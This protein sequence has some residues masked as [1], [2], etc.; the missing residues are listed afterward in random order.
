MD[1]D[2]EGEIALVTGAGRGIGLAIAEVLAAEGVRVIAGDRSV[3][4]SLRD[5]AT[6]T[7]QVDLSTRSGPA[8]LVDYAVAELG[9]VDILVNNVGG[10]T[11]RTDGF[12]TVDDDEWQAT[13][14]LNFFA[15]VRATR[16][17]LPA[18]LERKGVIINI[19]SLNARRPQPPAVD[20]AA[21][22][23]ALTN[24]SKELA[25][26]VGPRGV[27]VNTVSPGPTRTPIWEAP[28]GF[29]AGLARAAD[30]E[31]SEF[32]E[33]MPNIAGTATGR[34]TE[35]DEVAA[36]VAF[37]A[38]PRAGNVNGSD[39]IIDGGTMKVV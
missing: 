5:A 12:L 10:M 21:A 28:E 7:L 17:A 24:L 8:R 22:K 2:L 25:E 38:S 29:G 26:E 11:A 6:A 9:G 3:T 13:F 36:L 1:L 37:L 23:A 34:F 39:W 16:A 27:R 15:A 35:P 18:L 4:A 30:A 32:L 31:Q 14:E 19:S 20:Y 33:R